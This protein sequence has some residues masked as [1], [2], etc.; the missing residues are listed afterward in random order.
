MT[1]IFTIKSVLTAKVA[2]SAILAVIFKK[3][4][5]LYAEKPTSY[6]DYFAHDHKSKYY[7]N[8]DPGNFLGIMKKKKNGY[9]PD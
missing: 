7:Y 9:I 4:W 8:N 6:F 1:T 3:I 2:I 5:L